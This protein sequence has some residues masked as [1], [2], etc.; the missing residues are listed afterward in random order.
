[1]LST[2]F[3]SVKRLTSGNA[4]APL[5]SRRLHKIFTSNWP[6][7]SAI[8]AWTTTSRSRTAS[9]SSA[10]TYML[11]ARASRGSCVTSVTSRRERSFATWAASALEFSCRTSTRMAA[12]VAAATHV[13][14]ERRQEVGIGGHEPLGHE[15]QCFSG[16]RGQLFFP[17]KNFQRA[18]DETEGLP[19]AD[20]VESRVIQA[21]E[22]N[23]LDPGALEG[24]VLGLVVQMPNHLRRDVACTQNFLARARVQRDQAKRPDG[25]DHDGGVVGASALQDAYQARDH[26]ELAQL[27]QNLSMLGEKEEDHRD[28]IALQLFDALGQAACVLEELLHASQ[29]PQQQRQQLGSLNEVP[30]AARTIKADELLRSQ[31]FSYE[32]T[33]SR[34]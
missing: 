18:Q 1:M 30:N 23:E 2:A 11:L 15:P 17:R 25:H 21:H 22:M 29:E 24:G 7:T 13:V 8:N 34:G 5:D 3:R 14:Y 19:T 16:I 33:Q 27:G 20:R 12:A 6:G 26:A 10:F 4:S 32:E 28:E 31:F 9:G